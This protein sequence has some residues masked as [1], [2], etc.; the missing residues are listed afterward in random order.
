MKQLLSRL[1]P[2]QRGLLHAYWAGNFWALYSFAD[3]T[4]RLFLSSPATRSRNQSALG[5]V[6]DTSFDYLWSIQPSLTIAL[7]LLALIPMAIS[8]WRAPRRRFFTRYLAY[9]IFAFFFFGY[10]VH[11]KAILMVLVAYSGFV[12]TDDWSAEIA[13]LLRISASISMFPLLIRI[14]GLMASISSRNW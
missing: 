6:Q 4:L 12:G 5:L 13:I 11:E 9:A 8:V 7:I 1:F 3:K 2:F 10:H 14:N